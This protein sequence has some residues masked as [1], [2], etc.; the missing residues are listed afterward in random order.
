MLT[1]IVIEKKDTHVNLNKKNID[2]NCTSWVD[3]NMNRKVLIN[4]SRILNF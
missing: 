3:V 4:M 1:Q 2:T